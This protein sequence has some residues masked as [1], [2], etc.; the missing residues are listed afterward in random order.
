MTDG[1]YRKTDHLKPFQWKPGQTG[2]PNGRPTRKTMRD[3][4]KRLVDTPATDFPFAVDVARRLGLSAE[5]IGELDLGDAMLLSGFVAAFE[6]KGPQ[7]AE[8]MQRLDGRVTGQFNDETPDPAA[9]AEM[10]VEE[11]RAA[12]VALYRSV[13]VDPNSTGRE[14]LQAQEALNRLLGLVV[15]MDGQGTPEEIAA[16]VRDFLRATDTEGPDANDDR[17]EGVEDAPPSSPPA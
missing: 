12:A 15:E 4:L 6:G 1:E 14:K 9:A 13:I 10:T 5:D 17:T 16:R 7:F 8:I 3:R 2:N 11:H